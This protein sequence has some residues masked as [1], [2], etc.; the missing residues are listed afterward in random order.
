MRMREVFSGLLVALVT[1]SLQVTRLRLV[2]QGAKQNEDPG[3]VRKQ[4]T[5]AH[6]QSPRTPPGTL[7]HSRTRTVEKVGHSSEPIRLR[8]LLSYAGQLAYHE[9][10][11]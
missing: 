3:E 10:S 6:R 5:R 1:L 8:A 11:R 7:H 2:T 9:H 4:Q